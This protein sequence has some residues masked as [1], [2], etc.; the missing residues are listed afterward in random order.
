M[1]LPVT[2]GNQVLGIIPI[3]QTRTLR[4]KRFAQDN[5]ARK[6]HSWNWEPCLPDPS[7]SMLPSLYPFCYG[8]QEPVL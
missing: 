3:F 7:T 5:T 8:F 2:L 4:L 1:F 6:R